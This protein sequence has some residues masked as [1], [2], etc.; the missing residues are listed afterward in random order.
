MWILLVLRFMQAV[1]HTVEPRA[2]RKWVWSAGMASPLGVMPL[3]CKDFFFL[4]AQ[5]QKLGR[6]QLQAMFQASQP[7]WPT[8]AWVISCDR[9]SLQL[10]GGWAFVTATYLTAISIFIWPQVINYASILCM[11]THVPPILMF[12]RGFLSV[13]S[14]PYSKDFFQSLE[15]LDPM[16]Q[17]GL[18]PMSP[19]MNIVSLRS[20]LHF[21]FRKAL[22]E[23]AGDQVVKHG[24]DFFLY[25]LI[26]VLTKPG[27][28]S[29]DT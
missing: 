14:Q 27:A 8:E 13:D 9:L 12:T 16:R 25:L 10:S 19:G 4:A 28:E 2:R 3:H 11:N 15:P 23:M 5:M 24:W 17:V 20:M 22:F 26:C 1:L 21:M 6:L 18:R 7:I 29:K